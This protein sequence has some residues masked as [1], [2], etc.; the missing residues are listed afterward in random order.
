MEPAMIIAAV[1]VFVPALLMIYYLLKGYTYPAVEE[2]FF[3]DSTLFTLFAVGLIEGFIISAFYKF[4]ITMWSNILVALAFAIIQQMA[5]L[6]ILNLKRF[7]GK[8]DTVFYGFS[9]GIGQGVGM[10]FGVTVTQL[11]T[12]TGL[13]SVDLASWIFMIAF[14][15]Q[16]LLIMCSTGSTVGEG[17]AR[18]RMGEFTMKGI[19]ACAFT[20]MM[21][22]FTVMM[23]GTIWLYI[24][25]I[26][27]V[28]FSVYFFYITTYKGLAGVVE[29][30][31]KLEGRKRKDIP[32]N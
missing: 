32:R 13:E 11:S 3:K 6:V 19:L 28:A 2:P 26:I 10:A 12:F 7:H 31:L 24:P 30:V 29:D 8:S 22:A 15:A 18:L 25:A 17:V 1:L 14:I 27:M 21:W 4:F 20:M 9:L 5:I 16:Q 23:A